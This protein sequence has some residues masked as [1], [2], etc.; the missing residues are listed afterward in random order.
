MD[1]WFTRTQLMEKHGQDAE[2]VDGIIRQKLKKSKMWMAHQDN[3]ESE[4]HRLYRA[5]DFIADSNGKSHETEKKLTLKTVLEQGAVVPMVSTFSG[6]ASLTSPP[7]LQAALPASAEQLSIRD[8]FMGGVGHGKT[9]EQEL[10]EKKEKD[11]AEKLAARKAEADRI[12]CLPETQAK[13]W[14]GQIAKQINDCNG[15]IAECQGPKCAEYVKNGYLKDFRR[16]FK[17]L[18]DLREQLK[19]ATADDAPQLIIDAPAA[20]VA[21][22]TRVKQWRKVCKALGV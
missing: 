14:V 18:G 16:E 1:G 12:M 19:A 6:T 17:A 5:L 11:K 9:P 20:E 21:Y 10:F 4:A 22:K 13:K 15:M 8:G 3:P 2:F 7:A